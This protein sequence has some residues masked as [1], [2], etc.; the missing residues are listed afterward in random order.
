M[1]SQGASIGQNLRQK[2]V[3]RTSAK[4][5]RSKPI[6]A[7]DH[8]I[9]GSGVGKEFFNGVDGIDLVL[10]IRRLQS[11]PVGNV[12]GKVAKF[13]GC[14]D[15]LVV[16]KASP[17]M[18]TRGAIEIPAKGVDGNHIN[19]RW[20]GFVRTGGPTRCE[21]VAH[22]SGQN[23]RTTGLEQW[24]GN[25]GAP[26]LEFPQ[27]IGK[28]SRILQ[29]GLT[30]PSIGFSLCVRFIPEIKGVAETGRRI[31][32][33]PVIWIVV[34]VQVARVTAATI[35]KTGHGWIARRIPEILLAHL[36]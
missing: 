32:E 12:N 14:C 35:S 9:G 18:A 2:V 5:G 1:F 11:G 24:R 13:T 29:P 17:T 7:F 15:C 33:A 16:D 26:R 30:G 23:P 21:K 19:V 22:V 10:G 8:R 25:L 4:V 34:V 36:L 6:D 28:A 31:L 27:L 20:I 3:A